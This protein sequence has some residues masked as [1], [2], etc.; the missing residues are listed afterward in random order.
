VLTGFLG[1]NDDNINERKIMTMMTDYEEVWVAYDHVVHY[2]VNLATH[3]VVEVEIPGWINTF[4]EPGTIWSD[5]GI[6]PLTDEQEDTMIEILETE[7]MPTPYW[8]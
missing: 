4:G 7:S 8:G 6:D 2:K 3:E 5:E 1:Y